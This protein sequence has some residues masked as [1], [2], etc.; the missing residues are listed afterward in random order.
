MASLSAPSQEF[1]PSIIARHRLGGRVYVA[2]SWCDH[3]LVDAGKY[4]RRRP[5][6]TSALIWCRVATEAALRDLAKAS[7]LR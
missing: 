4:D 1:L 5:L 3:H 6:D 2:G 7:A